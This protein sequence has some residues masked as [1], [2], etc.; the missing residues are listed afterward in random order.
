AWDPGCNGEVDALAVSGGAVYAGGSFTTI[1]WQVR[2]YVA[3]LSPV[4]G[5]LTAW[6]PNANAP[7]SALMASGGVNPG[8]PVTVYAGGFFTQF[9]GPSGPVRNHIA[10]L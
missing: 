2:N 4:T 10:K 6:N 5:D 8:P 1:G 3:A 9:G 7:V